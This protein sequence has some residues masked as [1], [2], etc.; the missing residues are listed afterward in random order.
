MTPSPADAA[1][2]ARIEAAFGTAAPLIRR[3]A[4]PAAALMAFVFLA[5]TAKMAMEIN[6][7]ALFLARDGFGAT[8]GAR[9]W[10]L[11]LR[12]GPVPAPVLLGN[13]PPAI[14][15]APLLTATL[16]LCLG[17]AARPGGRADA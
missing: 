2:S 17:R 12:L 7:A 4:L 13:L 1:L 14:Y 11:A 3:F 6:A 15:A 16:G 10:L 8:R 5:N 9:L